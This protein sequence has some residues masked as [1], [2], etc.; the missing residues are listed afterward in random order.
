MAMEVKHI[1]VNGDIA[2]IKQKVT[3]GAIKPGSFCVTS[4]GK[5][6][7]VITDKSVVEIA[8][9]PLIFESKEEADQFIADESSN[10]KPGQTIVIKGEDGTYDCF[11][12]QDDGEGGIKIPDTPLGDGGT[13][14]APVWEEI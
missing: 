11:I 10:V 4:T 12:I 5:A 3:E 2:T 7:L 14:D 6:A 13:T 9:T 1:Y 8:D